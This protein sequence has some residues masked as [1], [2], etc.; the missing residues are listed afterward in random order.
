LMVTRF[1]HFCGETLLSDVPG[2]TNPSRPTA[3]QRSSHVYESPSTF[4]ANVRRGPTAKRGRLGRSFDLD[5]E[6]P[7]TS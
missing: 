2:R 7:D 6:Q 3:F 4:Q 5:Q 1:L